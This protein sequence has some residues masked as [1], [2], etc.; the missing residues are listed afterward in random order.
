MLT[1]L[2]ARQLELG[3]AESFIPQAEDPVGN[4]IRVG[5]GVLKDGSN[6]IWKPEQQNTVGFNPVTTSNRTRW[7]LVYID[8]LGDARILPGTE[9]VNPIPDLFGL[10]L[11]PAYGCPVAGIK[12]T[13]TGTV[14]VEQSDIIDLRTMSNLMED[15]AF[16]SLYSLA[17]G[18]YY[19]NALEALD[20]ET[21]RKSGFIGKDSLIQTLP[22][23]SAFTD[24]NYILENDP[25]RNAI[26]KLDQALFEHP[27]NKHEGLQRAPE[28]VLDEL[29]H[30]NAAQAAAML[31]P[32]APYKPSAANLF[33]TM[34]WVTSQIAITKAIMGKT[35]P[36][37]GS[38]DATRTV[39]INLTSKTASNGTILGHDNFEPTKT[40]MYGSFSGGGNAEI[41][42]PGYSQVSA[43]PAT[44]SPF[45]F[46]VYEES[47]GD[48]IHRGT[49]WMALELNIAVR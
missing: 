11:I 34:P 46:N 16:T 15:R 8:L 10:P 45:V 22:D 32:S 42:G 40:L 43:V 41:W 36:F 19:K 18:L 39:S 13:E 44:T 3:F 38:G 23:Y 12:I 1:K 5:K 17:V 2:T 20:Q 21:A 48:H 33:A 31:G 26:G 27:H 4:Q 35:T 29:Y 6:L 7:D 25:V 30:A 47:Y 49:Y 14:I 28:G 9:N 37:G 24:H